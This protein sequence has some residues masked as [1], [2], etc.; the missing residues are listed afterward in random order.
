MTLKKHSLIH[1][2]FKIF[3][4][5]YMRQIKQKIFCFVQILAKKKKDE[6]EAIINNKVPKEE[7]YVEEEEQLDFLMVYILKA[8]K[9][10]RDKGYIQSQE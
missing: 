10:A 6:R 2:L 5:L 4:T 8:Q 7:V 9:W 1:R 3:T